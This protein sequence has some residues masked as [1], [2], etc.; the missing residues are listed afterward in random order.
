LAL[1]SAAVQL[2]AKTRGRILVI[3]DDHSARLLLER[4][5]RRAGHEVESAEDGE[6]GLDLLARSKFDLVVADKNLPGLDGLAVLKQARARNPAL[7]A[8]MVTGFPTRESQAAA[9][10]Q[11]IHSYVTKPFGIEEIVAA[12]DEALLATHALVA[13]GLKAH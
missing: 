5:L 9:R 7:L 4:V 13:A 12:C 11:G 2:E 8:V 6:Q 3:D 10:A 1:C